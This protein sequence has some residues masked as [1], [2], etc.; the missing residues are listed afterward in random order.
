MKTIARLIEE[1]DECERKLR[2][3]VAALKEADRRIE[4]VALSTATVQ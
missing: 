1:R 2:V 3:F 4:S